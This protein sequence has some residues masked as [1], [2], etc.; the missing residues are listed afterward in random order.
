VRPSDLK[1]YNIPEQCRLDMTDADMKTGRELM[2]EE[3]IQKNP[4]WMKVLLIPSIQ[5]G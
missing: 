3:F 1:K 5:R 4:A 2:K